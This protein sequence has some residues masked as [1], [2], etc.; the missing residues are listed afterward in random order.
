MLNNIQFSDSLRNS[1]NWLIPR[2]CI[3]CQRTAAQE[4]HPCCVDCYEELPFQP[5]CCSQCGQVFAVDADFCGRCLAKP[6]P[7]DACFCPF[8]YEEPIS[9]QI[10]D[11]KYNQRPELAKSLA[12]LL[13]REIDSNAIE[14]PDLIIPVPLHI[15]RLRERG[16]NQSALLAKALGRLLSVPVDTNVIGKHRPTAPQAQLTFKQRANNLKGCFEQKMSISANSVVILDDVFTT[17]ATAAEIAKILKRNG[18]DYVEIWG[19]AHTV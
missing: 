15:S 13:A 12:Q 18:V 4:N 16:Y 14:K 6:P 3:S 2:K 7:F 19:L 9:G 1:L 10:R 8:E 17:G 5:H 11:F